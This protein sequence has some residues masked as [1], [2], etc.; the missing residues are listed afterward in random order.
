MVREWDSQ[1]KV[2]SDTT[3]MNVRQKILFQTLRKSGFNN[4]F[5]FLISISE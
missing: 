2:G 4:L 5:T 3:V 1:N